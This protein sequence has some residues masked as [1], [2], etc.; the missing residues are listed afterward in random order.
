MEGTKQLIWKTTFS[1]LALSVMIAVQLP[2]GYFF[3]GYE[4][5]S[6]VLETEAE[7]SGLMITQG[8]NR[9]P[10]FWRY[11]QQ[12]LVEVLSGHPFGL[13]GGARRIIDA[14][15]EVVAQNQGGAGGFTIMRSHDIHDSGRVIGRIEIRRPLSPLIIG[16]FVAG[17]FGI[18]LGLAVY[19]TLRVLPL[20]A[21]SKA[22]QAL[23]DQKE[24]AQAILNNIPDIAWLKDRRG[25]YTAINEPFERFCGLDKDR[26]I[27][28]TDMEI[29]PDD[30][31]LQFMAEDELVLCT[32]IRKQFDNT[33]PDGK[34][35]MV[36]LETVKT[37]IL[38]DKGTAVI[39]TGIARDITERR[40]I[41]NR[42]LEQ[43]HFLQT[44]IDA[45]PNAIF[46]KDTDGVYLG[47]NKTFEE[48]AGKDKKMIIGRTVYDLAPLQQADA[49][50]RMDMTLFESKQVQKY[51]DS[52]MSADG[53]MHDLLFIKAP[54][55]RTD[56]TLGGLVGVALDITERKQTE[57]E[58]Q[59][60]SDVVWR[61]SISLTT[62]AQEDM[63]YAGD[64]D[65]ALKT[66]TEFSAYGLDVSRVSVWF[67]VDC[68]A[69]IQCMDMYEKDE[70]RHSDGYMLHATDY[71][72]Y[73]RAIQEEFCIDADDAVTDPRTREF[74]KPY[75]EPRGISSMLDVPIRVD[76]KVIGVLCHEQIGTPRTWTLEEKS[77]V[78]AIAAFTSISLEV[79]ARKMAE[80]SAKENERKF[81]T[82][83]E[84]SPDDIVLI[85]LTGMILMCNRKAALLHGYKQ[86]EEMIKR[87][88]LDFIALEDRQRFADALSQ[89]ALDGQVRDKTS[90]YTFLKK[91]GGTF[92]AEI[93]GEVIKDLHGVPVSFLGVIRDITDRKR[94]EDEMKMVQATL[95]HASRLSQLGEMATG[96]AHE[97]N[98]PL[99]VIGMASQ[100]VLLNAE[101]GLTPPIHPAVAEKL[102]VIDKQVRRIRNI[103]D[104]LRTF[105]RK[106]TEGRNFQ[107]VDVTD[108]VRGSIAMISEQLRLRGIRVET[109]F[110]ENIPQIMA[111]PSR[112]EQVFLNLITNARDALEELPEGAER[113]L[114]INTGIDAGGY[115]RI[116]FSDTG[117]GVPAEIRKKIFDP[118]FTT[119]E[120]GKGTGLGLS[121]SHGIVKEHGGDI[122]VN[123]SEGVGSIFC[124]ILPLSEKKEIQ[125]V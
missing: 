66:V 7:M 25:R 17:L 106:D 43:Y 40:L 82:L 105:A 110:G 67:F 62:L 100:S 102:N 93:D 58:K 3:F 5:L 12:R 80:E 52:V 44:V 97:I 63:I 14:N 121:I 83:F 61:M 23:L 103:I 114:C 113:V 59:R 73:F 112:L 104:H 69:G 27:G 10:E 48:Y 120:V 101:E 118:F 85:D 18:I 19:A 74:S 111:N 81:R 35:G 33:L 49:Y 13:N 75:L 32:G 92:P 53:K 37:P 77:F 50:H 124:V 34:G 91:D 8:V 22:V 57:E 29:W 119:K 70:S 68:N 55:D 122:S 6:A 11:Q 60:L 107:V 54:F 109:S 108:V 45:I 46:I 89:S 116:E 86:T 1:G 95:F 20:R 15:G 78:T 16:T 9:N 4:K 39:T 38:D 84:T 31:G 90:L 99:N 56:G 30:R 125:H 76:G 64:I 41:E 65:S 21:L 28:K 36:Y 26:V 72:E 115:V 87:N 51:E 117:R 47:C 24:R 71:P 79:H 98:Q 96:I 42:L 2:L 88:F 123:V 94:A